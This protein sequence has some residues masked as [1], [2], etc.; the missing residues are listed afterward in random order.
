MWEEKEE[1]RKEKNKKEE[2]HQKSHSIIVNSPNFVARRFE[3]LSVFGS[4]GYESRTS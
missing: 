3:L 1:K 4:S 2:K